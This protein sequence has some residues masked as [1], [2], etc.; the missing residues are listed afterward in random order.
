MNNRK[1]DKLFFYIFLPLFVLVMAFMLWGSVKSDSSTTDEPIH[2]LSGYLSLKDGDFRLNPEHPF[3][4]KQLAALPLFLIKPNIDYSEKYFQVAK[5]FYYDSWLE[6]RSMAQN[7]LYK[8]GN[9]ADQ[10]LLYCRSVPI[11]FAL[12]FAV[13]IFLVALRYYGYLAAAAALVLYIFCPNILAHARLANTDLWMSIFFF[14]SIISFAAYLHKPGWQKLVLAGV[15]F[16]LAQGVKFSALTLYLVIPLLY[17]A[18]YFINKH[19]HQLKKYWGK[20]VLSF[21]IIILIGFLV[22]GLDYGLKIEKIPAYQPINNI[23]YYNHNLVKFGSTVKYLQPSQYFKGIVL[24]LTSTYGARPAYLLGQYKYGGWWYYFPVAFAVKTPL[25]TIILL[26]LSIIFYW[27]WKKKLEFR[28][29]V[30]ITPVVVYMLISMTSKLNLGIRHLL[31]IYPFIY[32]WIGA[33][34]GNW[35]LKSRKKWLVAIILLV[36]T[37]WYI[38]GNVKIYPHYLAYFNELIGPQNATKVLA[39]SNID[40]GQDLE[41]LKE[42]MVQNNV[43]KPIKLCY[44]WTSEDGPSY[45]GIDWQKLEADN[46]NQKGIIAIGVSALQDPQYN[47]LKKYQPIARVGYSIN[48]YKID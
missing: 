24:A 12:I 15:C 9:N 11:I 21:L 41:R 22:V 17:V 34:I 2:I 1:I 44:F 4:G 36:M 7:F 3:I 8:M 31:P 13:V 48:I 45:Y 43:K 6:T 35:W 29:Y 10:I 27:R 18:Y 40:W 25:P 42:W 28:D 46:P 5:D 23:A 32:L 38:Y 30:I 26:V 33:F 37:S 19:Q 16:G 47:W 20:S 39:D 14:L